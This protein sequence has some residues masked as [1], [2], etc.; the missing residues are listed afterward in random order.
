MNIFALLKVTKDLTNSEKAIVEFILKHPQQFLEMNTKQISQ[1]CYVSTSSIYRLCEKLN[2]SGLSELKVRISGSI[3]SYLKENENI[4]FNFP[5]Q[6][7]QTHFEMMNNLKADYKQTIDSTFEL[8]QLDQLKHAVNAMKKAKFIDIY[9]SAGNVPF[10]LNFQFQMQEIGVI[11]NVPIDEY[12]QRLSAS[13]SDKTHFAIIISFGGRGILSPILPA[14]LNQNKTPILLISSTEYHPINTHID[15]QLF[16]SS[17][18]DHYHKISSYSTR[19]SLLYI[20]D[21]SYTCYFELDYDYFL[22]KKLEYY[23]VIRENS[24]K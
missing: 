14:I 10:A 20:L 2:L 6:Q 7:N 5:I 1:E 18:E 21:V 13:S 16:M 22:Q 4:D 17:H 8:F 12:R 9:T 15:Y 3:E 23:Q 11:V 19:L 24:E